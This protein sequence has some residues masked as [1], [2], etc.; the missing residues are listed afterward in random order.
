MVAANLRRERLDKGVLMAAI[1][2]ADLYSFVQV[3]FPIVSGGGRFLPNWHIEAMCHELSQVIEGETRRLIITV[4]PRSLKSICPSVTLPPF[5]LAHAP[6][7]RF[8]SPPS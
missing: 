4:P 7:P 3:S 5:I 2:R 6:P 8:I 1:L